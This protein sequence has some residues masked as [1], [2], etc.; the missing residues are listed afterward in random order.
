MSLI[1]IQPLTGETKVFPTGSPDS[2]RN[3]DQAI[4]WPKKYDT[5]GIKVSGTTYA[6]VIDVLV[7]CAKRH[8]ST[9]VDFMPVSVLVE[10]VN[11][12]IFRSRLNSFDLV[13]PDGQPV[14][15]CLNHFHRVG[16]PDTVSGTTATL[17]LCESAARDEIGVY[18]YGSTP[19]TLCKFQANLASRFPG[20]Q[21]VGAES[22]PFYSLSPEE[23]DAV[24]YRINASGAGFVFIGL[25]SPRQENFVWEQRSRIKAVQLCVGAAFDFIAG[26]KKR[27]PKWMQDIGLEWMYRACNE[28]LRLGRRYA[29]GNARFLAV[30]L[31]ELF[32]FWTGPAGKAEGRADTWQTSTTLRDP[33]KSIGPVLQSVK[34]GGSRSDVSHKRHDSRVV[35]V[36]PGPSSRGGISAVLAMHQNCSSWDSHR[37]VWVETMNGGGGLTKLR[38]ALKAFGQAVILLPRTR[39]MHIHMALGASLFRKFPFFALARLFNKATVVHLHDFDSR[40]NSLMG[41]PPSLGRTLCALML[42]HSDRVIA[43][44][45]SWEQTILRHVPEARTCC[46]PNPYWLPPDFQP[47]NRKGHTVLYLNRIESRKGYENLLYAIPAVLTRC[48]RTTFVLA[49]DGDVVSARRIATDL[50]VDR[51]VEFP[52]WVE[53]DRKWRLLAQ[54]DILCLPS[55]AEGVP[56]TLLEAMGAGVAV[57]TTPVGGIPDVVQ[58]GE[59]GILVQPGDVTGIAEALIQLLTDVDLRTRI[60]D[61]GRRTVEEMNSLSLIDLNLMSLYAELESV[62]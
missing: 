29:S 27:A 16:L 61:A 44:S 10:A 8:R 33:S 52:G 34:A 19:K 55:F 21:I 2:P 50:G 48:P 3:A 58:N 23:H 5:F 47:V 40:F 45:R 60:S 36:G 1:D 39:L 28:P 41:G 17:R 46:L 26:T 25:G 13:C 49:G 62:A 7:E 57:V 42:R 38:T 56:I 11:N 24:A 14:R 32:R 43:L 59:N 9:T 22:P 12:P 35:V 30:V 20:L 51:F 18:L 37:C 6:E 31:P 15:W 54:A 53:G 4:S